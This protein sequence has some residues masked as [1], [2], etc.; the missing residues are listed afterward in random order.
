MAKVEVRNFF[1]PHSKLEVFGP[2]LAD[3]IIEIEECYNEDLEVIDACR[4]PKD[5]VFFK[6]SVKLSQY[7]MIRWVK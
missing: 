6:T 4:H 5:I 1:L 3:T 2:N 7:D